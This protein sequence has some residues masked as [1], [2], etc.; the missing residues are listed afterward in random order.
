VTV[1]VDDQRARYGRMI[2]CHMVADSLVELHAMADALGLARRW[3]Q[4]PP[5]VRLPHYD[6]SLA[7]RAR[8]V[9]LGAVEI[10]RR[11]AVV[12]ARKLLAEFEACAD[13]AS[14]CQSTGA[15]LRA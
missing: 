3:F 11:D 6:V 14:A 4:C 10:S 2:M 9:S 15:R 1:Y 5:R 13:G 8:A 7:F 12:F